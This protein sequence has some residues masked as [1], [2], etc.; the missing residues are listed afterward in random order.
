[1]LLSVRLAGVTDRCRFKGLGFPSRA[2]VCMWMR[3]HVHPA[4][5]FSTKIESPG[6]KWWQISLTLRKIP[7]YLFVCVCTTVFLGTRAH[8]RMKNIFFLISINWTHFVSFVIIPIIIITITTKIH[9][10]HANFSSHI[11]CCLTACTV[12]FF[13]QNKSRV[14]NRLK[15]V[16]F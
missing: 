10:I 16:I 6:E 8:R 11:S 13:K 1:M 14:D 5:D 2:R 15:S 9:V 4:A 12:V 7:L 3:V